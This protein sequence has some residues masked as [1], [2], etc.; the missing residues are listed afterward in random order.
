M[1]AAK[2]DDDKSLEVLLQRDVEIFTVSEINKTPVHAVNNGNLKNAIT[3][4]NLFMVSIHHRFICMEMLGH[5]PS[6]LAL[7]PML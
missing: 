6:L 1:N 4:I 5:S 3:L 2:L 7:T